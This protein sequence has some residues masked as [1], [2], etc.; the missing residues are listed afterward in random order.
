[1]SKPSSVPALQWSRIAAIGLVVALAACGGGGSPT[2]TPTP[3]PA[4]AK[5]VIKVL[6]D[7][8]PVIAV[9]SG[10]PS[11]PWA[12]R[13]NI[14][15]SDSGGVAF[16][17][18]SMQTTVISALS[19]ATLV[20]L[21]TNAFV[22]VKIPAYGQETAQFGVLAYRMENFT[23]E[24]RVNFKFNF[25]DDKGNASVYDGSV[26]VQHIGGPARLPE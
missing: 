17:V 9:A 10:D 25:I 2:A 1:M 22:G 4:P 14:Q 26:T 11:Y 13:V 21:D 23:K 15:L 18:S 19:G 24:G 8:S 12:F 20:T 6:I 5:A 7:P 16:V 3:T